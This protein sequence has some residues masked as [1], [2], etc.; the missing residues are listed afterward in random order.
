MNDF[1]VTSSLNGG[2][3]E[4][5]INNTARAAA[6]SATRQNSAVAARVAAGINKFCGKDSAAERVGG[7]DSAKEGGKY[8]AD[9]KRA[10][11][12]PVLPEA[13]AEDEHMFGLA[14]RNDHRTKNVLRR[15]PFNACIAR[16]V[17]RREIEAKPKAQLAMKEEWDTFR[18]AGVWKD[19]EVREWADVAVEA[20]KRKLATGEDT[21]F[22]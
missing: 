22:G 6:A 9:S 2:Q 5:W 1:L 8:P 3:P 15:C 18:K 16:P 17:G 14:Y 4:Q 20:R 12:M 19:C 13:H 11:A 21:Q 10:P 7:K